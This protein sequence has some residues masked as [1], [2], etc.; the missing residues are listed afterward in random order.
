MTASAQRLPRRPRH[1]EVRRFEPADR[2]ALAAFQRASFGPGARQLDPDHVRWLY[3]DI[4]DRDEAGPQL[5]IFRHDDG[6]V[7]G[8]QGGM[9][10]RLKAGGHELKASW[11]IDLMVAPEWR[12]RGVGPVLSEAHVA[13]GAVTIGLGITE[14]AFRSYRSAGWLDLGLVP[15]WVRVLDVTRCLRL[16]AVRHPVVRL[17]ARVGVPLSGAVASVWIWAAHRLGA[18]LEPVAAFDDRV[19]DL[20]RQVAGRYP[21]LARRDH[22]SLGW[23]FDAVPRAD[24]FQRGYLLRKGAIKGYLVLRVDRWRGEPVGVVIDY[25]AS[26]EWLPTLL[27][28]AIGLAGRQGLAAL[29]CRTLNPT[30]AAAFATLGFLPLYQGLRWPTRVMIRTDGAAAGLRPILA[31]RANWLITAGDSDAG[32]QEMGN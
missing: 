17:A 15:T 14:D 8:Q 20:W 7:V 21:V 11:G 2:P 26:P 1:G 30:G 6:T 22:R 25:L 24:R 27:A 31:R 10:F 13:A 32:F 9:P 3:E 4:P 18:R 12:L 23:R 28:H 29:V 16:G 5:W 19:D